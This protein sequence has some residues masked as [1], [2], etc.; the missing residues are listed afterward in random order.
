MQREIR[1][2]LKHPRKFNIKDI[3]FV[4]VQ[5]Q[6]KKSIGQVKKLRYVKQGPY[7][8]VKDLPSGSYELQ[9]LGK[10]KSQIIKKFGSDIFLCPKEINPYKALNT[11]DKK[12]LTLT[13]K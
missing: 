9:L 10:P 4:K 7:S 3:L 6:S 2:T 8:I 11:S 1:I 12:I 13:R 5:V